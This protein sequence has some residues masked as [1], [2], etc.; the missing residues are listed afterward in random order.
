M[1]VLGIAG[2]SGSGKTTLVT[3]LVAALVARGHRVSTVKHAHHAFDIDRPGK[4]SHRHRE[5]GAHEV[6][7]ASAN[8]WALM[9]ELRGAAEPDLDDLLRHLAPVDL[10]LVEGFKSHPHDKIEVHRPALAQC[11]LAETDP[12][13]VAIACDAPSP[14]VAARG[15]PL[16]PLADTGA[17]VAFVERHCGLVPQRRRSA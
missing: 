17:I 1:R 15:L 5:S 3:A 6:L 16:L 10:V 9:H 14:A 2:W 11:L 7:V 8:R 12:R 4:D 13:I